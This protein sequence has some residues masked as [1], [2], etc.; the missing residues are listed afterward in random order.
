MMVGFERGV[1]M[2]VLILGLLLVFNTGCVDWGFSSSKR[3]Q[4]S[5]LT[6]EREVSRKNQLSQ[7]EYDLNLDLTG[8]KKF[9]G[10]TEIRFFL[11]EKV[12]LT[13]DFTGGGV[14]SLVINDQKIKTD[15]QFYIFLSKENLKVG[16]NTVFVEYTHSYS[17]NGEG[18]YRYIDPKDN[19]VYLYTQFEPYQANQM[20]PCFDQPNLKARFNL[21]VKVPESWEVVSTVRELE[22]INTDK[23][24]EWIFPT[25]PKI[26]TYTFSLHAGDYHVWESEAETKNHKIPLRLMARQSLVPYIDSEEWFDLTKKGFSFFE[27]YFGYP[28][29]YIKYDQV[30]VPDFNFGAMENVAAVTFNEDRFVSKG[31][32]TREEKR[33]LAGTLLHEM[34]HMWFGNLVT[35]EWWNDLWLNESFATYSAYVALQNATDF[36]ESWAAFNTRKTEAYLLDQS[37]N[38]HPIAVE[39]SSSTDQAF[40]NFDSITYSKGASA[41][42]QLSFLLG[43]DYEKGLKLYFSRYAGENTQLKDFISVMTEASGR[44]LKKWDERWL[45]KAMHNQVEVY[46]QCRNNKVFNFEL[47]QTGTKDYPTL[48]THKTK[49]TLL[50]P[51]GGILKRWRTKT[52][53]YSG[54]RTLVKSLL[55]EPCPSIAY[56]NDGDYDFVKVIFDKKSLREIKNNLVNIEDPFL[57][58]LIW[59]DL[60]IMV[61]DKRLDLDE[62]LE[63]VEYN[64]LNEVRPD[65][66][67]KIWNTVDEVFRFYY[68]NQGKDWSLQRTVW[69]KYFEQTALSKI[70]EHQDNLELQKIW[71]SNL[72]KIAE[73]EEVLNLLVQTLKNRA[74]TMQ[75]SFL[76]NQD[77]RW[78]ILLALSSNGYQGAQDLIELELKKDGSKRSQLTSLMAKA[79]LPQIENKQNYFKKIT[80]DFDKSSFGEMKAI[81]S[82][83]FPGNQ[84]ELHKEFVEPFYKTLKHL[85]KGAG[86]SYST[87]FIEK[88]A[89][90]FCDMKSGQRL[91]DYIEAEKKLSF[92]VVK[93]LKSALNLNEVCRGIRSKLKLKNQHQAL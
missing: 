60:W 26:S 15:D 36:D 69:I 46:F 1:D 75:L 25:S 40:A 68:P 45:K 6:F 19:K 80:Q 3:P 85:T 33:K 71:F 20:F 65:V 14:Q 93:S 23:F 56:P 9:L 52:I 12:D 28:Y 53:E 16:R 13:L 62:Y 49:L 29:P 41:L 84:T 37:E 35:M 31:E 43:K 22:K 24:A 59:N 88:M 32:K 92:P 51:F 74:T 72:I 82:G 83:L 70:A 64:G 4:K 73:S 30:I 79:S 8:E 21:R 27:S 54:E 67:T 90:I 87:E 39:H 48:R 34:A 78:E 77:Q 50:R 47:Y 5:R 2:K 57:R 91:Q 11:K 17:N 81:M 18:L 76:A 86:T 38:T 58:S 42:K 89:P 61:V 7:V 44:D 10:K 63:L 55:G 66:L